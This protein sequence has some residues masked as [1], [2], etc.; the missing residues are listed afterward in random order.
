MMKAC[1]K[2]ARTASGVGVG[3]GRGNGT[4]CNRCAKELLLVLENNHGNQDTLKGSEKFFTWAH[5]VYPSLT[6]SFR[7]IHMAD[8]IEH[9]APRQSWSS[10]AELSLAGEIAPWL[11]P[12]PLGTE[13][14]MER[15]F[16]EI[17]THSYQG[18]WLEA[19]RCIEL[20]SQTGMRFDLFAW[21]LPPTAIF[22]PLEIASSTSRR[23]LC[24]SFL[25]CWCTWFGLKMVIMAFNQHLSR[26][27]QM[28]PLPCAKLKGNKDLAVVCPPPKKKISPSW[29]CRLKRYRRSGEI[30]RILPS[31]SLCPEFKV[32]F[33]Q[34][35]G[36]WASFT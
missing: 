18:P 34:I 14:L 2:H 32:R 21:F 7:R 15:S 33:L 8:R 29:W 35:T 11:L 20:R 10:L 12:Q 4:V 6:R 23:P 36:P 30:V 31:D 22:S 3:G 13:P 19:L 25:H 24:Y 27:T 26:G 16:Q 1:S 5:C 17:E 9:F 28:G